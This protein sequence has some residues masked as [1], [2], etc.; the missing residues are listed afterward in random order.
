MSTSRLRGTATLAAV[1]ALAPIVASGTGAN[2]CDTTDDTGDVARAVTL[3]GRDI[4]APAD[5]D[6]RALLVASFHRSANGS[7]RAWRGALEEDTRAANW[8]AYTVIVLDGAPEL[9]RRFVVRGVRAEVPEDRRGSFLVV[10]EGSDPWRTLVGSDGEEEDRNDAVFVARLEDGAV[11]ARVRGVVSAEAL[12][13]L[14]GAVC[15]R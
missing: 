14:F 5:L 3:A 15:S 7:A 12:D 4:R 2:A 11:C 1:L 13:E 9:I 8:S 10:E 6:Q